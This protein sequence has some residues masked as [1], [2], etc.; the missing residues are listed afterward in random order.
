M[1]ENETTIMLDSPQAVDQFIEVMA[2]LAGRFKIV[3]LNIYAKGLSLCICKGVVLE[4]S[5]TSP[6]TINLRRTGDSL[7]DVMWFEE[8]EFWKVEY[9][10]QSNQDEF[11][12]VYLKMKGWL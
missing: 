5:D 10:F 9:S 8:S 4:R 3:A 2:D 11:V 12:H 1:I 6:K 7:N